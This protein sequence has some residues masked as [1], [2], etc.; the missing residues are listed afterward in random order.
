[1]A[2]L[3]IVR[4]HKAFRCKYFIAGAIACASVM[5]RRPAQKRYLSK[6]LVQRHQVSANLVIDHPKAHHL[7]VS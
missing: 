2:V 4:A 5:F 3:P 1:M 7:V 6:S